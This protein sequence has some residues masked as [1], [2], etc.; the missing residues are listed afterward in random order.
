ML[1]LVFLA[2]TST[3]PLLVRIPVSFC[4]CCPASL[5]VYSF[6][7]SIYRLALLHLFIHMYAHVHIFIVIFGSSWKNCSL[8]GHCI[9]FN[10]WIDKD[11]EQFTK[12]LLYYLA[13]FAGGIPVSTLLHFLRYCWLSISLCSSWKATQLLC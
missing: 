9:Y 5:S 13:G 3:T 7:L 12:Q 10:P 8:T 2:V 11:Q 6:N 4:T 1:G